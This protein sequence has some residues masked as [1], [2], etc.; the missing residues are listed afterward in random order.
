MATVH[1]ATYEILRSL[2]MTTIFG[3]PGSNELPFLD[4]LPS[5]FRYML[6][7]HEGAGLA[8]ADGYCQ[9]TGRPV[10]VSLHAAA[11]VGQAMGTLVNAQVLGTPLVIMSG[12]QVRSML[13]LE[14]QLTS[15][16]A[17]DLPRPLVKWSFEAPDAASVP[18]VI[19]RAAHF[20][21]AAPSGPVFVSIPLDDWRAEADDDQTSSLVGRHVAAQPIPQQDQLKELAERLNAAHKPLFVMGSDVDTEL[22]WKAGVKLSEICGAPVF[23]V[24][25]PA[26]IPFPTNH[27]NFLGTLSTTISKVS[28]RLTGYDLV[29]VF[30][31]PAFRYH[32]WT[33]GAYLPKG[34][35]LVTVTADADQAARAPMGD[36]IVGDPAVA[37]E[38]L[39]PLITR[40]PAVIQPRVPVPRGASSSSKVTVEEFNRIVASVCPPETVFTTESPSLGSWWETAAI[41]RPKSFFCGAGGGLGFALP[42]AVG[43][44]LAY[45]KRPVVALIG[46]GSANYSITG[47]WTAAQHN[48]PCTFVIVRNGVYEALKDFGSFLNTQVVEGMDLPGIDFVSLAA[49]YGLPARRVTSPNDFAKALASAIASGTPSLIEVEVEPTNSGMFIK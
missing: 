5:D 41:T 26:R 29:V 33:P 11:G 25:E 38:Q 45:G 4:R 3:N 49:G 39:I 44:S 9:V 20:A 37:M 27:P 2:G 17:I 47:L 31:G 30:G 48:L 34:T 6:A 1:D 16:N 8:M 32:A 40:T 19:A 13:T 12:Q 21:A 18:A 36:A 28:E 22:G 23:L 15:R 46:D 7:L 10:L 42:A 35:A 24:S 14:G 43:V